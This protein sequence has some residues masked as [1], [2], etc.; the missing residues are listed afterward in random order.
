V[1]QVTKDKKRLSKLQE[2]LTTLE[3]GK[4]AP[5]R[6]LEVWM[7]NEFDCIA[8]RWEYYQ[9]EREN[10]KYKPDEIKQYELY[11]K[12]ALF[13]YNKKTKTYSDKLFEIALE[14]LQ[15]IINRDYGLRVWFDRNTD[16]GV[17]NNIGLDP[18]GIPRVITSRSL[19]NL[20][21]RGWPKKIDVKISCVEN[22]IENLLNPISDINE[23]ERAKQLKQM[24]KRIINKR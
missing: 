8:S 18:T 23:E 17:D 13:A 20:M 3:S 15:E 7:G 9:Q 24:L 11:L 4:D 21:L 1:K 10:F 14:Y 5:N 2:I 12:K 6:T 16:W 19:D 22:V